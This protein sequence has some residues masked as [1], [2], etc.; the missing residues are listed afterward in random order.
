VLWAFFV[1][2]R[3]G[4]HPRIEKKELEYIHVALGAQASKVQKSIGFELQI[5]SLL[6]FLTSVPA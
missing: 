5:K 3:P 6:D 4:A 2:D 1:F